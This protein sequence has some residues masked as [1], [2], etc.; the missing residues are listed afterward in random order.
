[1]KQ[2]VSLVL[3]SGGARG[4]AHIGAIEELESS[5]YEIHS[6]VGCSMG[7]LIGGLYATGHLKEVT[8][9]FRSLTTQ[10]MLKLVDVSLHSDSLVKGE[11]VINRLKEIVPDQNIEDL[12]IPFRCVATDIHH[13]RQVVFD[14]GSL[15][16][17][18]RASISI[19]MI[20]R[21][22]PYE[23]TE[24]VDGGLLNPLPVD[25]ADRQYGDKLVVVNVSAVNDTLEESSLLEPRKAKGKIGKLEK[26]ITSKWAS[27]SNLLSMML[28]TTNLMIQQNTA[29]T[30]RCYKPDI[31][32]NI[33]MNRL[34]DFDYDR[35]ADLIE[36]GREAMH[37]AL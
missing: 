21:P 16:D 1:M 15:Y 37:N 27:S 11:K 29:L 13:G 12:P 35:A 25:L 2:Q 18:I 28:Q 4:L 5:G 31:L 30:L 36:I 20:F 9:W 33:P 22:V 19:P 14:H 7:S 26:M 34:G 6:V 8:E 24:L 23:D 17:A 10:E 32:V 3:S